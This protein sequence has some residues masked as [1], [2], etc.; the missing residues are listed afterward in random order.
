MIR[1]FG[2]SL[3]A[4][5]SLGLSASADV[6]TD[7]NTLILNAIRTNKASPPVASRQMAILHTA[8]FD[9]VN[10]IRPQ[11]EA[12]RVRGNVLP[13]ASEEAAAAA[14]A[15]KVMVALYPNNAALYDAGLQSTLSGIRNPVAKKH[16][17]AWGEK[18][19]GDIMMWRS[20]D[21]AAIPIGYTPGTR[22]GDWQPTPPVFLPALLPQWGSV[23]PFGVG[24][25]VPFRPPGPPALNSAQWAADFNETK[26]LGAVNS[27]DRTPDQTLIAQFWANGAG[28]ETPPGHWNRIAKSISDAQRL[29]L[30]E[31][32]RLFAL[33]NIAMAD[34]AIICWDCKFTYN[35]WR[36][37][38]AIRNGDLDGNDATEE[39]PSWT[40][41]LVTPNFPEYTS[42]HSTFSGA[43]ARVIETF[44]G[45]DDITFTVDSDG[46]PGQFRTFHKVSSA[47]DESGMSRIYGGIHYQ[48]AN[49]WGLASGRAAA[50]YISSHL[51][52][53]R[54]HH[55]S[56]D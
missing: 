42:G 8:M 35:F 40:P 39:D 32:A 19:A 36:P 1:V 10:G 25:V 11:Y 29:S 31:N 2:F 24:S 18:V 17:V 21:G 14:A 30:L 13:A 3:A 23:V 55:G 6:V 47:A 27:V 53:P 16:G 56:A 5:L 33:L 52:Q 9:A 43:G 15:R 34:A 45:T 26:R 4:A 38:T 49:Q 28:T 50:D 37:V 51:L 20:T 54:H 46:A 44:F 7:W 41:L 12:Y 22:V 48:S